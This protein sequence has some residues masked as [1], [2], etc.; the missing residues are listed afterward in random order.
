MRS[1]LTSIG[2]SLT[3]ALLLALTAAAPA[4]ADIKPGLG[5]F[6]STETGR[7]LWYDLNSDQIKFGS[8]AQFTAQ[9]TVFNVT[10]TGTKDLYTVRVAD[11]NYTVSVADGGLGVG[12]ALP[13][14]EQP[15]DFETF[16]FG[17]IDNNG[18]F[19]FK[20]WNG[21]A[22]SDTRVAR[23][24]NESALI[25]N[26]R[27]FH[28]D[29]AGIK[30]QWNPNPYKTT[31]DNIIY[32]TFTT[33]LEANETSYNVS[34][35]YPQL[36]GPTGQMYA[37]S[38]KWIGDV[39]AP[40]RP[41]LMYLG[42]SDARSNQVLWETDILDK[43]QS[44]GFPKVVMSNTTLAAALLKNYLL[45][46]PASPTC[47]NTTTNSFTGNS[48]G[49]SAG[50]HFI[51]H[52][53]PWELKRIYDEVLERFQFD[54]TRFALVGTGMGGRGGLRFLLDYP[55]LPAA[56]SMVSGAL[57]TD[58]SVYIKALPYIL[59]NSGEGCWD[60]T[61]ANVDGSCATSN[62]V[63]PT[64]PLGK[65]LIGFPI[66]LW[67]SRNDDIDTLSEAQQT[68]TAVNSGYGGNCTV[69]DTQAP[70]HPAMA[71]Y[72]RDVSDVDWLLS[73]QRMPDQN[74]VFVG[75]STSTGPGVAPT[76]AAQARY[77]RSI[78]GLVVAQL[79]GL[80]FFL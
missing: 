24:N 56:V 46:V 2:S 28:A 16:D 64:M 54:T 31:R 35:F 29:T 69:I 30:F 39:H 45:V 12:V 66:R 19:Y 7:W 26:V 23:T 27:P 41:M 75:G 21:G 20:A 72:S 71:Y 32:R 74:S 80:L 9:A 44:T 4:S 61:Q 65:K 37:Y 34:T 17:S 38:V 1:A 43:T 59:W 13:N 15:G 48:C 10:S 68:C 73:Y 36:T 3:A 67:S 51:K 49:S 50:N 33:G 52:Y 70:N 57:E 25:F 63:Q 53:R 14:I 42:G 77:S 76:G 22:Y 62:V 58:S 18:S 47:Y 8:Q 6:T 5:T 79:V 11:N 78:V 60:V 40:N 55:T